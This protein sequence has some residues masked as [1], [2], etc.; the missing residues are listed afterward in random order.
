MCSSIIC[1]QKRLFNDFALAFAIKT[2]LYT[3]LFVSSLLRNTCGLDSANIEVLGIMTTI[4]MQ[5]GPF[6]CY[7]LYLLVGK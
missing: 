2:T 5:D 6:L 3:D 1:R 4:I 7:R